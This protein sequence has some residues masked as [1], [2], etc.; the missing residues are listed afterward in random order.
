MSRAAVVWAEGDRLRVAEISET[1]VSLIGRLDVAT[2]PLR[3]P[4]VSREHARIRAHG[5]GFVLEHLGRNPTMINNVPVAHPT[6]LS[7]G[8]VIQVGNVR[9]VF[10]D[11]AAA[12]RVSA[13][14]VCSHCARENQRGDTECWF[15]GASLVNA[16]SLSIRCRPVTC[17][18][19]SAAGH[20]LDL[21]SDEA[22]LFQPNGDAEVR[23]RPRISADA[24]AFI[25]MQ[26]R[27]PFLRLAQP[28]APIWLNGRS[29]VDGDH[30]GT[31][32]ELRVGQAHYVLVVR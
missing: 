28:G 23:P 25:E 19:I 8:A 24:P 7:D 26:E 21:F 18:V 17:R 4:T 6:G 15:C 32:D 5:G 20:A 31:G 9:L 2:A 3:D 10:Y 16:P 27:R 1:A 30:L 12:D 22:L 11:L 13:P 14:V 29:A